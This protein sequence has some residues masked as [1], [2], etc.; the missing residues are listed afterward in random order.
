[1]THCG[2]FIPKM[3]LHCLTI[4]AS[5]PIKNA[6]ITQGCVVNGE[7][8]NSVLFTGVKVAEGAKVID[9]VLMPGAEVAEGAIVTRALVAND[10][11]VGKNAVVGN[12]E[13]EH[14][15]LVAK[16]VKGED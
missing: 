2:R 9:S 5:M 10:I 6:F 11:K 1:M 12:A 4:S 15:E 16:R 8:K 14:I 7:V 13:S 3:S